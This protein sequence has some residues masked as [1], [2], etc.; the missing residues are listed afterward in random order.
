MKGTM[1]QFP[2]TL[3]HLLERAGTL[4]PTVEIVS[5]RPDNS[6]HRYTY[7]EMHR[8]ARALAAALQELGLQCGDRVATL[9]WN[10]RVHLE[11]YLG[12]PSVGG[13]L[14][15]LNLRLHP[16]ELAHII[17]DAQDR[18][19]IVDDVLLPVYE[20][21]RNKVCVQR[22]FVVPFSGKGPASAGD[23]YESLLASSGG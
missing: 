21:I 10:H 13:V 19:L 5:S 4:F 22:V 8:R 23:D 9:M 1:M 3:D 16:D 2:L 12:I 20:K 15:T 17:N 6:I 11:A 18:W 7:G 14:H